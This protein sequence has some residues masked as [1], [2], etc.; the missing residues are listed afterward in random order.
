MKEILAQ[1]LNDFYKDFDFYDYMDSVENFENPEE[2][3]TELAK[4]LEDPDAVSGI[5]D[6]LAGIK[7]E[8]GLSAEQVRTLDDLILD[9]SEVQ[10]NLGKSV[11]DVI[12]EAIARSE[13]GNNENVIISI[14]QLKQGEEMHYLRFS[15]LDWLEYGV[16]SVECKNYNHVYQYSDKAPVDF[17]NENALFDLLE[18]VYTKFNLHHPEDFRGHSLST[19][20]VV[21]IAKGNAAKAFYCDWIGFKEL[22]EKFVKDFAASEKEKFDVGKDI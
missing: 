21:V 8:G 10:V 20:D 1:K 9:L 14:L 3:V 11:R 7:E 2:V 19:S 5:L 16:N 4:Q 15:H 18:K 22:P 6:T 12:A 17:S 13:K